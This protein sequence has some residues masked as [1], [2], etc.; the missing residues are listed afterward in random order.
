V[1]LP[2]LI[3]LAFLLGRRGAVVGLSELELATA[4]EQRFRSL[5]ETAP[6]GRLIV[7]HEGKVV[8]V[9]AETERLF[10]FTRDELIGA[11]VDA[12]V[13]TGEG[14]MRS[15]RDAGAPAGGPATIGAELNLYGRRK[16]GTEFPV[17][18]SVCELRTAQG[19]LLSTAVRDVTERKL[20]ADALAHQA[21][22]DPLTGLPNRMLFLDRL[23][24]ALARARRS[25]GKVAVV[26]LDLDDFKLVNDTRGH[27]T[28]DQL[29]VALT[30]RLSAALRPGD[31]IARFGGDEFVVL[32][33]DLSDE[34]DAAAI[35]ERI[36]AACSQPL[37]IDG[38]EHVVTLS[39][40]VVVVEDPQAATPSKV[41]RDADAAMYRAKAFGTGQVVAFDEGMRARLIERVATESALRR[42][43]S[44]GELELFYQP[45]I[46]L[47]SGEIVSAE[48]LL[49]WRHP[50]RGLLDPAEFLHV[51][52]SSGLIV[53]IGLWVIKEAC[54]QAA[55]WRDCRPDAPTQVSVNLSPHEVA[56]S[57]IAGA[58]AEVLR[59]AGLEPELLA[60]EITD[61]TLL[62]DE[63]ES[64]LAL[65]ELKAL[66][67]PLVLDDFGTDLR[68]LSYLKRFAID[69][70]KIDRSLV[71]GLGR[72]AEDGAIV[73]AVLSIA[74]ALGVGVTAKGVE[75]HEQL[76]RLRE[77]G[78]SFAQGYLLARPASAEQMTELLATGVAGRLAWVAEGAEA[79]A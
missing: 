40:G 16:D 48:A 77:Q 10:G 14:L 39:A 41:L 15:Y 2:I 36:V 3:L 25:R 9:N 64:V 76:S 30:P 72:D 58:V 66:G 67:V 57:D 63:E 13:P 73:G 27:D 47:D 29:L 70:F 75:T 1:F 49:R 17:E 61:G 59:S 32:C 68:S 33:E 37:T 46:S 52:Q 53:P 12:L 5:F 38:Y 19:P 18:I 65:S 56:C 71:D 35:A 20:A 24:H 45:V 74:S 8:L 23:E 21:T 34:Q 44:L 11:S 50:Q 6:D 62:E 60:L 79:P 28:G 31:T 26:F 42:A 69:A 7:D 51:A 4:E 22:H 55:H 43:L 54:R 78:C